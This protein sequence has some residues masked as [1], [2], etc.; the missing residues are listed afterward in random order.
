[1]NLN[2]LGFL[3]KTDSGIVLALEA[4]YFESAGSLI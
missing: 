2:T 4:D 3:K 1:M